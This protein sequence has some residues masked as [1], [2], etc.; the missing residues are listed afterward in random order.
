[1]AARLKLVVSAGFASR[2]ADVAVT[3][4]PELGVSPFAGALPQLWVELG[5]RITLDAVLEVVPGEVYN[6]LAL[7]VVLNECEKAGIVAFGTVLLR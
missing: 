5:S 2:N 4:Q 6:V 1:M 3:L 7:I